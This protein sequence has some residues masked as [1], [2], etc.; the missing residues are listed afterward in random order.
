MNTAQPVSVDYSTVNGTAVAGTNYVATSGV[1]TFEPGQNYSQIVVPL[2]PGTTAQPGGTF[3][4]TL[5]APSGATVGPIGSV[6]VTVTP[7]ELVVS[8]PVGDVVA[9]SDFD[10][11]FTHRT[12]AAT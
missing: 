7:L 11:Q 1:L 5:T 6:Q 3:S 2:L 9:G 4:I 10:L 12:P 8:K